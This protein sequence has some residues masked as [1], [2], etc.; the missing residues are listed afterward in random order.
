MGLRG[1][2]PTP[3]ALQI[4]RGNP[5][6]RPLNR[7]EPQPGKFKTRPP[8]HLDEE[9][10]REWKRLVPILTRMKVLGEPDYI[11]L[12]NLCAA[13]STLVKARE[14]QSRLAA[15]GKPALLIRTPNGFFQTSPLITIIN[16]QVKIITTLLR[17]FGMTP[18]ARSRVQ[19]QQPGDS[20]D[21]WDNIGTRSQQNRA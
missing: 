1:P 16:D 19:T 3:T 7:H 20:G 4:L 5:G 14:E 12:A 6:K 8:D 21:P 18:S 17:E 13:Y 9:A 10:R 15:E 2:A 11:A